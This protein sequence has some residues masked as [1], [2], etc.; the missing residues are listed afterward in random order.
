MICDLA[1]PI[2]VTAWE[3]GHECDAKISIFLV[4]PN[5][6]CVLQQYGPTGIEWSMTKEQALL[7]AADLVAAAT[8]VPEYLLP[9]GL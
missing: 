1:G 3:V 4:S 5:S 7:L 8:R 9:V 2:P 6:R